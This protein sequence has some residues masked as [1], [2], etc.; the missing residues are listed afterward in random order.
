MANLG[1]LANVPF[2]GGYLAQGEA[3]RA[4]QAAQQE[5]QI[6][7]LAMMQQMQQMKRDNDLRNVLAS[8]PDMKTAMDQLV[9]LGPEGIK[10][11]GSLAA[12]AQAQR[13]KLQPIGSGGAI[14]PNGEVIAPLARPA[15][16]GFHAIGSGGA[17]G[18]DGQLIAPLPRP[19]T[20]PKAMVNPKF[21]VSDD[22]EQPHFSKDGGMT[23]EPIPGTTPVSRFAK[24]V[25][26]VTPPTPHAVVG[27][28]A[29]GNQVVNWVR[30]GEKAVLDTKPPSI[31]NSANQNAMRLRKEYDSNPEVKLANALEP[32][33]GPMADYVASI[34]KGMGNPVGDA[35]LVKLWLMT[36]HPKGDQ[37]SNMDYRTIEKLPDLFSRIKN[38]AG[39]F[40]F[41]KTLD[42]GTRADMWRSIA[43]KYDSTDK[44]R[45]RVKQDVL[46]RGRTM[47]LGEDSLFSKEMQQ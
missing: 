12:V 23:W 4:E 35:E 24:Q 39:N 43:S 38:V 16:P 18:P 20:A 25:P 46:S 15:A 28:D 42:A 8:S 40:A 36:T 26:N 1:A 22:K 17:I 13:G 29:N 9:K 47:Q 27:V 5:Q 19:E 11:A 30:P 32:K 7:S 10:A 6:K 3:N 37:I 2:L 21:P 33:V 14:G 31:N 41:G 45:Q 44:L 34:G